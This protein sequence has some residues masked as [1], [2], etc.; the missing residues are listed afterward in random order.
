M[1]PEK[2]QNDD[3]LTFLFFFF[4]SSHSLIFLIVIVFV[5]PLK[6]LPTGKQQCSCTHD[7]TVYLL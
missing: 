7:L 3:F 6:S 2:Y 5:S 4:A 1:T